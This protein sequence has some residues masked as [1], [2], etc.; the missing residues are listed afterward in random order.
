MEQLK[1]IGMVCRQHYE[2]LILSLVLLLLAVAVWR[3]YEASQEEKENVRKIPAGFERKSVKGVAPVEVT[4]YQT[5]IRGGTNPPGLNLSGK[6]NLFN[7]VKWQQARQG[8]P[9]IKVVSGSEVGAEAM[10]IVRVR[11]LQ[12]MIAYDRAASSGSGADAVVTGYHT[13]VTNEMIANPVRRKISQFIT[14]GDTNK[15]VFVLIEAKGPPAEPTELV[16]QLKD[17]N[18]EKISFAPGKPYARV[19]GHEAE[20]KYPPSGKTYPPL[21]TG[22]PLDIE[23]E[24]YKIV[25]ITPSK[26]VLSDDSNGKRYTIEEIVAP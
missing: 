10:R 3:I 17:F 25:D 8:G 11:P 18:N 21:R 14:I 22:S 6:H 19:V 5:A 24:P 4:A 20:L 7:P 12:L 1:R 9:V 26:V 13:V 2:K 16:A 15:Q 23:G